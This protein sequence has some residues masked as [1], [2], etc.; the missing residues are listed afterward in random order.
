M[1]KQIYLCIGIFLFVTCFWLGCSSCEKHKKINVKNSELIRKKD[2]IEFL[3]RRIQTTN[4]QITSLASD[5]ET[6]YYLCNSLNDSIKW[7]IH[8]YPWASSFIYAFDKEPIEIFWDYANSESPEEMN[9]LLKKQIILAMYALWGDN[10]D[11][12]NLV[13]S[14]FNHYDHLKHNFL[15]EIGQ[16][17]EQMKPLQT[18]SKEDSLTIII[19]NKEQSIISK[20]LETLNA[21]GII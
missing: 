8:N 3:Y 11:T 13:R 14:K 7:T 16:I 10:A 19:L 5:R 2:S 18:N 12:I 21:E 20:E 17:S 15:N 9:N 6:K 4:S 1:K